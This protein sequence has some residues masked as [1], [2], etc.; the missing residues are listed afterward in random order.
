MVTKTEMKLKDFA[1]ESHVENIG[2]GQKDLINASALF[3]KRAH[4]KY[5]SEDL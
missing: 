3:A 5:K 1:Q 4:Q 2:R